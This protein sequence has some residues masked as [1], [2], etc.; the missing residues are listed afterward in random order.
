MIPLTPPADYEYRSRGPWLITQENENGTGRS[1]LAYDL[2]EAVAHFWVSDTP[3]W[4]RVLVDSRGVT[5]LGAFFS[6]HPTMV[7]TREC[8]DETLTLVNHAPVDHQ[9]QA[10]WLVEQIRQGYGVV[11]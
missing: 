8:C 2:R 9:G 4:R 7:G 5:I 10:L 1:V 6:S 11:V 3:P